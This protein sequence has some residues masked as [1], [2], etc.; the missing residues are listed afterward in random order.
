VAF[1]A[2]HY[3]QFEAARRTEKARWL[4][5]QKEP[6]AAKK[7]KTG[8]KKK[9]P[10]AAALEKAA[11]AA[12]VPFVVDRITMGVSVAMT[13]VLRSSEIVD[14][15]YKAHANRAPIM[16]SDLRFWRVVGGEEVEVE[17]ETEGWPEMEAHSIHYATSR[18][19]QS[20]SDPIQR[21]GNE[22]I[23]PRKMDHHDP[24]GALENIVNFMIDYPIAKALH[25]STPL[26]RSRRSGA[27]PRAPSG[28]SNVMN[29]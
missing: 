25:S 9:P 4:A 15:K 27:Q 5:A 8:R 26:M 7:C 23:S 22:L 3:V 21:V 16:L 11:A 12:D 19:P 6:P 17:I 14:N 24:D 2:L 1:E 18:M 29:S 28:R 20:K 13:G 10:T